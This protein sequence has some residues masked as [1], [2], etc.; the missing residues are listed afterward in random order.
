MR[1]VSARFLSTLR[2]SHTATV[3]AFVVAAGQTGV[4]PDGDELEVI[5]GDV[6]LDATADIRSTLDLEVEGTGAFP[7]NAGDGLAPY[8]NEVFVRRGI[9]FGGG[10]I[11]WVSLGYFRIN[12]AEQ[13]TAPDGPIR[14]AGRDRMGGIV[15]ARLTAP[16]QFPAAMTYG[17]VL[18]QLVGEVYPWATIEWD[19]DTNFD[20]IGRTVI[21]EEERFAFLNDLITSRGKIWYWD[22]RGI[23]VIRDMPDPGAPVWEVNSGPNGVLL[24]LG[25]EISDEGV[26]NAVVAVGEALDTTA[27]PRAVAYDNN[28]ASPTYWDGDFGKVPRFFSSPFITTVDR[29]RT[30]A[31]ALLRENLGVPYN[32]DFQVIANPALEPWDPIIVRIGRRAETHVLSRLTVPLS[33][34]QSMSAETR[35]QTLVVIGGS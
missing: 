15:R 32:V 12:S 7:E 34:L 5:S 30:A 35:E 8:G 3:Q 21:A 24:S 28:P 22:H 33:A 25:R 14:I 29:A 27:P 10:S 19:D 18:A 26:Y 2:G 16:R 20:P 17:D 11:E 6:N 31:A 4:S 9:T 1:P 13:D 23:L